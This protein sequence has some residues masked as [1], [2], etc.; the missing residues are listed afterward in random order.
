MWCVADAPDGTRC[1]NAA[2]GR[3]DIC[4]DPVCFS[5]AEGNE[6]TGQF[7]CDACI[8]SYGMDRADE[9]VERWD[10]LGMYREV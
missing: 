3:C 9:Q 6:S 1:R 5:H 4:H 7:Q 8:H 2:S 10:K